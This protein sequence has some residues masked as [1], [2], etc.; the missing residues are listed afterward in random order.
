MNRTRTL[1]VTSRLL[2]WLS[3]LLAYDELEAQPK[4]GC[5]PA[6]NVL[7]LGNSITLHGPKAD[8]VIV[9]I[10]KNVS[11]PKTEHSK[12]KMRRGQGPLADG[13]QRTWH[14]D[15]RRAE[16]FLGESRQG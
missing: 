2:T 5:L 16:F 9:A 10:G 4:I 15:S 13:A 7:F 14:A 6:A 3:T 12:L 11:E 8:I 1:A